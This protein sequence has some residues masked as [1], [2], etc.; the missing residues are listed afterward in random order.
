MRVAPI[1]HFF[2]TSLQG[3]VEIFCDFAKKNAITLAQ[4]G[5]VFENTLQFA[6]FER[7]ANL[8]SE[9][10][11]FDDF[12]ALPGKAPALLP[13]NMKAAWKAKDTTAKV[14]SVA[15]LIRDF[16]IV[17]GCGAL[18]LTFATRNS[19]IALK[20]P[21]LT[22]TM[23]KA[24]AVNVLGKFGEFSGIAGVTAYCMTFAT[25]IDLASCLHDLKT[26]AN[27]NAEKGLATTE[28]AGKVF[29]AI[30]AKTLFKTSTGLGYMA[31]L[32]PLAASTGSN[33]IK[34]TK[35]H[36]AAAAA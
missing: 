35:K 28:H 36:Q 14:K 31:N 32:V 17:V 6:G 12:S 15:H 1:Q 24:Q 9:I 23:A 10:D 8:F 25:T 5:Q 7:F 19:A 3:K 30:F 22:N 33:F 18:I 2:D 4:I 13:K 27:R 20:A 29:A 26:K 11:R 21:G 34:A 16:S